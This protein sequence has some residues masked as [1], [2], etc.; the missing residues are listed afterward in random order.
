[1][2]DVAQAEPLT[3]VPAII[4]L[5]ADPLDWPRIPKPVKE[6]LRR[7]RRARDDAWLVWRAIA[8]ER[9][10]AWD[11]K[12][13]VEARLKILTG[14]RADSAWYSH[15]QHASFQRLS[16]DDPQVTELGK[17]GRRESEH[18]PIEAYR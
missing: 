4:R 16:D 12:R 11:E 15:T 18:W 3:G 2:T 17:A 7:L 13:A 10:E 6:K 1:M 14:G 8:D 5:N 9:Q